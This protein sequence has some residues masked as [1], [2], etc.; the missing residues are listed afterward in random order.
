MLIQ[1]SKSEINSMLTPRAAGHDGSLAGVHG[2][3]F[4][5][6]RVVSVF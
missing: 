6:K 2:N 4:Y 1:D 3:F 5:F